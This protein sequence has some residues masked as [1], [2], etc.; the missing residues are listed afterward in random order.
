MAGDGAPEALRFD[1]HL[2]GTRTPSTQGIKHL[3]HQHP[4]G[5]AESDLDLPVTQ[6]PEVPEVGKPTPHGLDE[7]A[8]G[9]E[10]KK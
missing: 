3:E 1:P 7:Q 4:S 8:L 5:L 9:H 10:L 2:E 6:E